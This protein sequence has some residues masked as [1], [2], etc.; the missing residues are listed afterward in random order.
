MGT[1]M[2][3]QPMPVTIPGFKVEAY[4][5]SAAMPFGISRDLRT[6][7]GAANGSATILR[8]STDDGTGWTA[9]RTFSEAVVG[10]Q[11]LADGE[12]LVYT[13]NSSFSGKVYRSTG[14]ATSHTTATFALVL[15]TVGAYIEPMWGGG[16]SWS[17]GDDTI[18]PGSG[19][20]IVLNEYGGQTTAS[21]DQ[22]S[23]ARR[24]YLSTD[25]GKTWKIILDLHTRYSVTT[26]HV[27]ACGYDAYWDRIWVTHGDNVNADGPTNHQITYSD[28]GGTTWNSLP[29]DPAYIGN[30]TQFTSLAILPECILFGGDNTPGYVR[31]ARRGYRTV[32]PAV[33]LTQV[34]G[35]TGGQM[36]ATKMHQN[37]GRSAAPI[38]A[39]HKS[40]SVDTTSHLY[41]SLDNGCS[42][43]RVWED[44]ALR[45]SFKGIN[46]MVGP[47]YNGKLL[48]WLTPNGDS[49]GGGTH[50]LVRG[51]LVIPPA[52]LIDQTTTFT[53]DGTAVAFLMP[54]GLGVKPTR[55]MGWDERGT[56]PT[57]VVTADATNIIFTV[58]AAPAN[59]SKLQF[60][61]RYAA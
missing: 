60:G 26:L 43:V 17:T 51:E 24:V 4:G 15:E 28:D 40:V 21:G 14:W 54:H 47:T 27:H 7:Y 2:A 25:Y 36:L 45:G 41:A 32:G 58:T 35:G 53:G 6:I 44:P 31:L 46:G 39:A 50:H 37:R 38:L 1:L 19:G 59:A 52:G 16:H 20:I 12:C 49:P 42:M 10:I 30:G 9:V 23:K 57:V 29:Q 22:T 33:V 61:A 34:T 3:R 56:A 18:R 11:E 48:L 5:T 55:L 13:N 8:Q